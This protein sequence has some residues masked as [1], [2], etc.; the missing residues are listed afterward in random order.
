MSSRVAW[1]SMKEYLVQRANEESL[2]EVLNRYGN[3]GYKL[4][5]IVRYDFRW[6]FL[7]IMEKEKENGKDG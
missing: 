7:I 1:G 6:P 2:Q 3:M 4:I 5:Q